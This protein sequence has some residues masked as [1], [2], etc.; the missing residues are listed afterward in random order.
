MRDL[1]GKRRPEVYQQFTS[2]DE[3]RIDP[4]IFPRVALR[5]PSALDR[6]HPDQNNLPDKL[7][8]VLKLAMVFGHSLH[9]LDHP[10]ISA[11]V[12]ESKKLKP[13]EFLDELHAFCIQSA[14]FS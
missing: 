12:Y 11:K 6:R 14:S 9:F 7:R 10:M 4:R 3:L 1:D 8:E 13:F 5:T 2:D